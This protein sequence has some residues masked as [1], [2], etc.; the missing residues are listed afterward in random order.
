MSRQK[1]TAIVPTF[2]EAANIVECLQ[3]LSWADEI[4]VVDSFSTDGTPELA[5][6]YAT[7]VIQHEYVNSATQKNWIIP[8]AAHAWIFLVDADERCTPELAAEVQAVLEAP[9]QDAYWIFRRNFFLGHEIKHS[10]WNTDKVIRLF[11]RDHR[12]QDLTVHAEV[13]VPSEKV[14]VLKA[15]FI[16]Y[17]IDSLDQFFE[18]RQRY[19]VW[20]AKDLENRGK[21]AGGFNIVSH[22]VG[23]FLKMYV[24]RLGFLDGVHGLALAILFSYYTAAKYI[25]LWERQLPPNPRHGIRN[26]GAVAPKAVSKVNQ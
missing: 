20:G 26:Q 13:I 21:R 4:I 6:P 8:Q 12:Y 1:V 10:G 15:K 23:N 5:R 16:H 24:L 17:T 2:N 22:S 7:R 25:R 11:Q 18:K 9:Q 3:S 14:G 19:A